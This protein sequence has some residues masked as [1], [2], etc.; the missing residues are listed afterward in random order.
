MMLTVDPDFQRKLDLFNDSQGGPVTIVVC[1]DPKRSRWA[2][3]AVPYDYGSHPLSRTYIHEG[4]MTNFLDGSDRRGVLLYR[5]QDEF[6][7]FLPLDD[8]LIRSLQY[9]DTFRDKE[10]FK[11]TVEN[12]E[13]LQELAKSKEMRDIAYGA[14]SYWWNV[15]N[16]TVHAGGRGNWRRAKGIT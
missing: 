11:N 7:N 2:V 16:T 10:H 6:K 4:L 15:A 1:W 5:W 9:A 8:R 13:V 14:K 12:P 3:Y